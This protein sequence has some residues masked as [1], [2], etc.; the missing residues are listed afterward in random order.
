M[1]RLS[2]WC[3]GCSADKRHRCKAI[4][5]QLLTRVFTGN[6]ARLA[7][8]LFLLGYTAE[9]FISTSLLHW[10]TAI[11]GSCHDYERLPT[12]TRMVPHNNSGRHTDRG[13]SSVRRRYD[14][15]Q[16]RSR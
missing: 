9:G 3:R 16:Q 5:V 7:S 8:A 15:A 1:G 13:K 4:A 14:G 12:S 2:W 10:G 6:M 11:R